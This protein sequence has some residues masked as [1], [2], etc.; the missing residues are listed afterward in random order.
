[1]GGGNQGNKRKQK[2]RKGMMG[3]GRERRNLYDLP[4]NTLINI[5]Q[6]LNFL[7]FFTL[8]KESSDL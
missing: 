3:A 6:H 7:V 4:K 5:I 8:M 1:M 2:W